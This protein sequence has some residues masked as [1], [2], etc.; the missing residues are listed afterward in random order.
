MGDERPR[1]PTSRCCIEY[2]AE[3]PGIE[4]IRYTTSHPNEFT[5]RLIDVYAQR[6]RSW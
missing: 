3:I 5:Q 1:S 4:R 2:V 6:A